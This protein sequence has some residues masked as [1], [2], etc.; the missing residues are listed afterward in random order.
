MIYRAYLENISSEVKQ[1]ESCFWGEMLLAYGLFTEKGITYSEEPLKLNLWGKPGLKNH[2]EIQYNISHCRNFAVC[3]ISDTCAVG[4]DVERVRPFSSYAARRE[5]SR[6]EMKRIYADPDPARA[7]F[8][9]WTLKES[10]VK[11]LGKGLC[12]PMK[13]VNFE[14]DPDGKIKSNLPDCSFLL[15]EEEGYITAVCYMSLLERQ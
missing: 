10:Y 14:I 3:I 7:F 12:H 4:I 11:A 8:R 2:P 9:Y 6:E 5:F 1:S 13:E 15:M